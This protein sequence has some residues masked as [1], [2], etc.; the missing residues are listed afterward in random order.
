MPV[1][2][3]RYF[4]ATGAAAPLAVTLSSSEL[5]LN[6]IDVKFDST[7]ESI[8]VQLDRVKI[9]E[10]FDHS[11]RLIHLEDGA[12]IEVDDN[13]GI[14]AV[15]AAAGRND[16]F[17]TRWQRNWR[18][19]IASFVASVVLLVAGY[20]WVLPPVAA[21]AA[22]KVPVRWMETLDVAILKQLSWMESAET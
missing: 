6:Q 17:V 12:V 10:H 5:R 11:P 3:A 8:L 22:T 21:Y 1:V 16:G 13:D 18:V 2:K 14:A 20:I 4:A 15:L 7:S 19:V 9:S